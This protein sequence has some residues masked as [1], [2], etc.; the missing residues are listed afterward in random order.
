MFTLVSIGVGAAWAFS[1]AALLLPGVFPGGH[2]PLYFEAAA[3]IT[4]L[5]LLGQSLEN[6]ARKRTGGAIRAL[7]ELAPPVARRVSGD[8]EKEIPV[9]DVRE[10]DLLRIRPGDSIPVDGV[11]AEGHSAVDESLLTG[12]PVPAGKS[13]GDPVTA[14]TRNTS[15]SL[16]VTATRIGAATTLSRIVR[17]VS[18]ASRSRAPVQALVD[19]VSAVFVPT[20][21]AVAVMSFIAW[22]LIGPAP[23]LANGLVAAVSVLIIACP[24]AM[25]LATPV[26]IMVGTGRAADAGIL[27][28]GGN[29]LQ[30]LAG[31]RMVA[32][33]KTGT[34]TRGRPDLV[35]LVT[36][37]GVKPDEALALAAAL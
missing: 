7:L 5:V 29:A 12:E 28:R 32:F 8:V 23:G 35:A 4:T 13:P 15:G 3:G 2:A 31:I 14:G 19:K 30:A 18:E 34:L 6:R 36:A 24:C 26:S 11:V 10:G 1:T 25:G 16:L 27:F 37:P 22:A 21:I 33:D 9:D 17:L 20:V